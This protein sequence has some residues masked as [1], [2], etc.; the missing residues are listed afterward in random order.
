MRLTDSGAAIWVLHRTITPS[1]KKECVPIASLIRIPVIYNFSRI[2]ILRPLK[3]LWS[4]DA[5]NIIT[6]KKKNKTAAVS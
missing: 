4:T 3:R 1:S 5:Q 2:H 6:Q